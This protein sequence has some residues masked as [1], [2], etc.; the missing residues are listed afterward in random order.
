[1]ARGRRRM[2]LNVFVFY[3]VDHR[4]QVSSFP[5]LKKGKKFAPLVLIT[6]EWSIWIVLHES[7]SSLSAPVSSLIL[8]NF[9]EFIRHQHSGSQNRGLN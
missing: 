2:A 7:L 6:N 1:M 8:L 4:S 5:S 9:S 3:Q